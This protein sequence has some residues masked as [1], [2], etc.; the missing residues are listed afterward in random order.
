MRASETQ[1][2]ELFWA[3]R[4]AGFNFGVVTEFVV[5]LHDDVGHQMRELTEEDEALSTKH[6]LPP[7]EQLRSK[8]VQGV[9]PYPMAHV[10]H[11]C[12]VIQR[13]LEQGDSGP[14]ADRDLMPG[15]ALANGPEEPVC[16]VTFAHVGD[17]YRGYRALDAL[18]N[19]LGPPLAPVSAVVKA[20]TY[21]ALQH[22]LDHVTLPGN[23]YVRAYLAP[24][25]GEGM[26]AALTASFD[27]LSGR[28]NLLRSA[29]VGWVLGTGVQ[30]ERSGNGAFSAEQR[31]GQVLIATIG[32]WDDSGADGR[33][34]CVAWCNA[35]RELL[36]PQCS[37]VYTNSVSSHA[38]MRDTYGSSLGRLR[39]VK[40]Q[41]DPSNVFC[42]NQN[43]VPAGLDE[44]SSA[45]AQ[46][47][48]N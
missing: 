12:S 47:N 30:S 41:W 33:A 5:Q 14:M 42:N 39:R 34:D 22:M 26:A 24:G 6:G 19:A 3:V 4:G 38:G 18:V 40:E 21:L 16:L 25:V 35:A 11:V 13:Y 29:L 20:D 43:V 15:F 1:N 7:Q 32:E 10:S 28:P 46:L 27:A 8:V 23:Y 17:V 45:T 9:M 36:L 31:K 2:E 48:L 37:S 44:A